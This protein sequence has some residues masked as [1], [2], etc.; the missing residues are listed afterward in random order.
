MLS[1]TTKIQAINTMLSAI[2]EPPVNSLSSTR[3]DSNIAEQI[4]DETSREV[5]TY[6]WH[7]NTEHDVELVPDNS[8]NI[9]VSDNTVVIDTDPTRYYNMDLILRGNLV[10]DKVTNSS[11]FS[12]SIVVDRI[13]LLD[14]EDLPEP[15]KYYIMIRAARIFGN[16]M[17]G[18]EKHH[19]FNSQ[20]EA[21]ALVRMRSFENDTADYSIFDESTTFSV[22]NRNASYRTY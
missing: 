9:V 4:L 16:R 14:F 8:G 21:T 12:S 22:I 13:I 19:M 7:F 6:G 17:I 20:D 5:Q 15:A 11:V 10:Y 1:K 18:S 2:G 3:A